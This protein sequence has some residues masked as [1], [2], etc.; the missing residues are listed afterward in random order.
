MA[1]KAEPTAPLPPVDRIEAITISTVSGWQMQ[2]RRDGSG[3]LIFGSSAG[4]TASAPRE[5]LSL[6]DIYSQLSAKLSSKYTDS[7]SIPVFFD[8]VDS[9]DQVKH[10]LYVDDKKLVKSI[11]SLLWQKTV[12]R[13]AARLKELLE[14]NPPVTED[15]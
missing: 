12:P 5:S 1:L 4:D 8:L 13:D 15:E 10:A 2:I 7:D 6:R 11:F 14:K 9:H 3:A